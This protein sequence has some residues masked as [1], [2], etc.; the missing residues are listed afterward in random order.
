M[1]GMTRVEIA[2]TVGQVGV[3][4]EDLRTGHAMSAQLCLIH[5][6]KT[7]LPDSR[8]GLQFMQLLGPA[9]PAQALHALSY[10]TAG[11]HHQFTPLM[12]QLRQL[13]RPV[14]DR[15]SIDTT[16]LV[17]HEAGPHLHHDAPC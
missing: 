9:C 13:S 16:P 1:T 11:Y 4:Q 12:R 15:I 7:H 2:L 10:R 17:G 6:D 5:L 3:S 14:V 8:S